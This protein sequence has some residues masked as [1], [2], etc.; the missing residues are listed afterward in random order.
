MEESLLVWNRLASPRH[1]VEDIFE[2]SKGATMPK[3]SK[4]HGENIEIIRNHRIIELNHG[5]NMFEHLQPIVYCK[6]LQWSILIFSVVPPWSFQAW[7][8]HCSI[9]TQTPLQIY[10]LQLYNLPHEAEPAMKVAI[11]CHARNEETQG[12]HTG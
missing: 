4:D 2:V 12:K 9:S 10:N 1:L 6:D 7:Q 11:C 3:T 5:L 8:L